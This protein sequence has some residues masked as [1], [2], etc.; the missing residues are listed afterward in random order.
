METTN[1]GLNDLHQVQLDMLKHLVKVCKDQG[2]TYF[3]SF[4]SLLGAVRNHSIIPWDD[5]IDVIMPYPDYEKLTNLPRDVWGKDLFMQTYDTDP[6][7]PRCYAKLRNSTTTLI[8]ADYADCDIN[9]GI[10]INI[11]PLIRLADKPDERKKQQKDA[12]LYKAITER[13]PLT[14]DEWPLR[15]YSS[16]LVETASDSKREKM[17]E[18][19]KAQVFSH[20]DE[21][22]KDCFVLA[23]DISLNL[24]LPVEWF[25][26][27]VPCE[28]E[29]MS[30]NIPKGWHEW[31]TLRYGDYMSVPI[32]DIQGD[33]IAGFLALDTGK[34]YTEYKGISYCC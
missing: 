26:E 29:G 23:G 31:L 28:F 4:G 15:L 25:S 22:T 3:L 9:Q 17:R 1:F 2:F 8:K 12:K 6:Q 19:L 27:A 24:A 7:Y 21:N 13:K 11:M 18:E 32:T 34:P 5:S 33:K 10:Y 16:I 30:V 20:E 14:A